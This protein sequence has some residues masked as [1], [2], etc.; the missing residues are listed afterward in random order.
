M[1][2]RFLKLEFLIF[3]SSFK[4]NQ[5]DFWSLFHISDGRLGHEEDF[6]MKKICLLRLRI[7][8][9]ILENF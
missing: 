4:N 9:L 8:N 3:L 5:T 6:K 7:A 1:I 2:S